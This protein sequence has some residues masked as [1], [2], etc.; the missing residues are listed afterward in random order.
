MRIK[1][2]QLGYLLGISLLL[3]SV[4]YFFASN[5]QGFERGTKVV[6]SMMI[7]VVFYGLSFLLTK[8]IKHQSFLNKWLFVAGS[9][10]FGL[11]VALIGQ[12]YNSHADS[13]QLFLIWLI[14]V[15]LFSII[16][17]YEPMYV[18]SY[19]LFHITI[20]LAIYPTTYY[21]HW[22]ETQLILILLGAILFNAFVFYFSRSFIIKYASFALFHILM[23]FS[24]VSD[25]F[26][27][28]G[29]W[30]NIV[31]FL[32]LIYEFLRYYKREQN[33]MMMV[34]YGFVGTAYVLTKGI[35][36]V[37]HYFGELF[38]LF[39]LAVVVLLL[40]GSMKLLKIVKSHPSN[41]IIK[42]IIIVAVT[43]ISTIFA[44]IAIMGLVMLLFLDFPLTALYI[45]GLLLVVIGYVL[46]QQATVSYTLLCTG[47]SIA[48][49]TSVF[50]TF[51]YKIIL[52]G[53][54]VFI[55][56]KINARG[57]N[58]V[59]YTLINI[60]SFSLINEWAGMI[61]WVF[62]SLMLLNGGYYLFSRKRIAFLF[63]LGYFINLTMISGI[64]TIFYNLSFFAIVTFL[65]FWAKKS[66]KSFEFYVSLAFWFIFIGYKYYDLLWSLVHKSLLFLILGLLFLVISVITERKHFTIK[67]E[68][69]FVREKWLPILLVIVLQFGFVIYQAKSNETLLTEGTTITLSLQPIDPRS[70][71]QGDY[72]NLR[73]DITTIPGLENLEDSKGVIKVVLKKSTTGEYQYAGYYQYRGKWNK[74]YK[75]QP[76]D[77]F[78]NGR[79]NGLN[80]II[81]GIETYFVPEGTG[82]DLQNQVKF[83]K[84]KVGKNG[85]AI[86]E[87]I[88]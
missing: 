41:K 66:E 49:V 39:L 88:Y 70:L 11:A 17:K 85:N 51:I 32:I 56:R 24:T 74:R 73:Y 50:E 6:L 61:D 38:L 63:S 45:I 48:T 37:S 36:L 54:L 40:L 65:I 5:W 44:T 31:Y 27:T 62:I 3:A 86:L 76:D 22:T 12:L 55:L 79:L 82:I 71:L 80:E 78:L 47:Y 83:A 7:M 18:L 60:I 10:S 28:Y 20:Y 8:L 87:K 13:Y 35:E 46:Q 53:M 19:L 1:F 77:V 26:P 72:I 15:F 43:L 14:P 81:Y 29:F 4:F 58:I 9:I 52:L 69:S 34:L 59:H 21:I 75:M 33:K 42:N 67:N 57:L 16:T 68:T 64:S 2:I 23:I 30:M 25:A 84:V